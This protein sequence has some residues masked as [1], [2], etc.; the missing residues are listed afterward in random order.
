M[1]LCIDVNNGVMI[2]N[3]EGPFAKHYLKASF[4]ELKYEMDIGIYLI[5]GDQVGDISIRRA[6]ERSSHMYRRQAFE[7][8]FSDFLWNR[9][10][11]K[12]HK[13]SKLHSPECESLEEMIM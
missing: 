7:G 5:W 13:H 6:V 1:T 11:V 10:R 8:Y 9:P 12:L 3:Q 2:W 4:R